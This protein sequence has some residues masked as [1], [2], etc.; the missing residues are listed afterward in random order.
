[1]TWV[2][3]LKE[4]KTLNTIPA[5]DSMYDRLEEFGSNWGSDEEL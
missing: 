2:E 3:L 4:L 1:M 5:F